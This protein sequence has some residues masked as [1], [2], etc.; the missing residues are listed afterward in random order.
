[1]QN[2]AATDTQSCKPQTPICFASD[3]MIP[4]SR[5]II[6]KQNVQSVC[7]VQRGQLVWRKYAEWGRNKK[8]GDEKERIKRRK[9]LEESA[10]KC[11]KIK[12][13]V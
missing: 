4:S 11:C 8:G 1:M 10:A 2:R 3:G 7:G 9:A 12:N 13:T 5:M 6:H